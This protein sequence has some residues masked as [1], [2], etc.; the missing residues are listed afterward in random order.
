MDQKGTQTMRIKTV[1]RYVDEEKKE[2]DSRQEAELANLRIAVERAFHSTV[3][4]A[5]GR[6][7]ADAIIELIDRSSETRAL[8]RRYLYDAFKDEEKT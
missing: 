1:T 3:C 8:L 4:Y 6:D 5:E 2:H 7:A